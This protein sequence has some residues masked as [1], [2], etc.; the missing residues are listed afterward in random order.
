LI[1]SSYTPKKSA[2]IRKIC[3]NPKNKKKSKKSEDFFEDLNLQKSE[4]IQK[5]Q[6]FFPAKIRKIQKIQ[7]FFEDLKSVLFGSE[8]P[9]D[10]LAGYPADSPFPPRELRNYCTALYGYLLD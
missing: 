2:K 1:K 3:K 5:I 6:R 4:T 10:L 8:Q 7:G 9:L